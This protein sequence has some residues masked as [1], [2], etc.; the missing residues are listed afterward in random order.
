MARVEKFGMGVAL[1]Q[2]ASAASQKLVA[3]W[4]KK[5]KNIEREEKIMAIEKK[6]LISNRAAAK[7][8]LV[9]SKSVKPAGAPKTVTNPQKLTHTTLFNKA[10]ISL[11][12]PLQTPVQFTNLNKI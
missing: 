5:I 12:K 11:S 2:N 9:A 3:R 8:A 10:Q 4:L 1:C 7:K 6:S